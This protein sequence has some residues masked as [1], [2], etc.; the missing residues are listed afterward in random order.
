MVRYE[1]SAFWGRRGS[2]AATASVTRN[3]G[4]AVKAGQSNR[5]RNHTGRIA[6]VVYSER[7]IPAT[8]RAN[9]P[10]ATARATCSA[11]VRL[12]LR[13]LKCS[14]QMC[15]A[16]TAPLTIHAANRHMLT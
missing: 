5:A 11:V 14:Y 12:E 2:S 6:D 9:A 13:R 15:A 1:P 8:A 3:A 10:I 16:Y 7:V 4:T